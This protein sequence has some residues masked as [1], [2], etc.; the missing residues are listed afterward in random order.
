MRIFLTIILILISVS[1]FSE[2][3]KTDEKHYIIR[4]IH[5]TASY[6]T[7]EGIIGFKENQTDE[8][9]GTLNG[10]QLEKYMAKDLLNNSI[11]LTLFSSFLLHN[12]DIKDS[13]GSYTSPYKLSGKDTFQINAGIK[14]YWKKFPWNR[15]VRTRA[16]LGEGLSYVDE[17]LDIEVENSN[18]DDKIS[19][20][21]ILNYLDLGLSFNLKDLTTWETLEDYYAGIGVSHRSGIFGLI[22]GVNGGSNYWTLFIEADF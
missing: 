22:D 4:M 20:A 8:Q 2:E 11:D 17:Y 12:Q 13:E 7:L 6:S 18:K 21:R 5:G 19:H 10:L 9:G 1:A 16:G 15:W 14:G 3:Q